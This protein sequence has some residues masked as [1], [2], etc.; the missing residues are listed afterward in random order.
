MHRTRLI[1]GDVHGAFTVLAADPGSAFVRCGFCGRGLRLQVSRLLT[2]KS[3]GC[4]QIKSITENSK[5]TKRER[6]ERL[7]VL[8]RNKDNRTYRTWAGMIARCTKPTCAQFPDYGGRGILVCDRWLDF[9][10]FVADMGERPAGLT[11]ERIDNDAGYNPENCRWATQAEQCLNRRC[12]A[13]VTVLGETL[14]VVVWAKR[15]GVPPDTMLARLRAGWEPEKAVSLPLGATKSMAS[16]GRRNAMAKLCDA[17]VVAMRS[18][19]ALGLTLDQLSEKYGV[20]RSVCGAIC[21]RKRWRH[22]P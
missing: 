5:R 16:S 7:G 22:V 21:Q 20:S 10:N 3:C 6:R 18:D 9:A 11:I 4:N 2:Y 13:R 19:K 8:S 17:D 14:P 12:T 1:P 15:A